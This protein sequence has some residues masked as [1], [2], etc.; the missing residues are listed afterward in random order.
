MQ[1]EGKRT[2]RDELHLTN[3]AAVE[4]WST[5]AAATG[6][7][8]GSPPAAQKGVHTPVGVADTAAAR[9]AAVMP[10]VVVTRKQE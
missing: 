9:R 6:T 1:Y 10:D 3:A 5:A 2:K 8:M 4:A 7:H